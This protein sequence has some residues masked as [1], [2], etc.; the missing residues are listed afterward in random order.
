MLRYIKVCN[1]VWLRGVYVL[2]NKDY[3]DLW[4]IK[5]SFDYL[6]LNVFFVHVQL[7]LGGIPYILYT[8]FRNAHRM[9]FNTVNT[10]E[11]MYLV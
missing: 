5:V 4:R 3:G 9:V 2:I 8:C 10:V 6:T 1:L 7:G 11:T